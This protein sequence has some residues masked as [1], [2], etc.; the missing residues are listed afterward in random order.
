MWELQKDGL[1]TSSIFP[2]HD[3]EDLKRLQLQDSG[4]GMMY[5]FGEKS[6]KHGNKVTR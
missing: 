2:T 4:I 1:A 3:K 6:S 5:N